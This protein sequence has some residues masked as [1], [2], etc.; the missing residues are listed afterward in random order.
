MNK[1]MVEEIANDFVNNPTRLKHCLDCIQ[2]CQ[3]KIIAIVV[4]LALAEVLLDD[5]IVPPIGPQEFV[6]KEIM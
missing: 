2:D 1:V 5:K 3:V 4:T 6:E